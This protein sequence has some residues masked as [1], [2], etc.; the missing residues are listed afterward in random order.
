MLAETNFPGQ[1]VG[2]PDFRL[3]AD[4]RLTSSGDI[5]TLT[6]SATMATQH[7]SASVLATTRGNHVDVG[8]SATHDNQG[9]TRLGV[10]ATVRF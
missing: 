8:V 5:E 2:R 4:A 3:G 7:T 10:G 6:T 1:A 9:D